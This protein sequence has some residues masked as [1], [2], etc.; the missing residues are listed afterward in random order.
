[1]TNTCSRLLKANVSFVVSKIGVA[2]WKLARLVHLTRQWRPLRCHF[3]IILRKLVGFDAFFN[4]FY[5]SIIKCD[6]AGTFLNNQG[7]LV[8]AQVSVVGVVMD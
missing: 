2:C 7:N 5:L 8:D 4:A 3:T 6:E 1:M